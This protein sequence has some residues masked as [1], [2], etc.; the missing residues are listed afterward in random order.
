MK[1]TRTMSE[2]TV[3]VKKG[4]LI[5][6]VKANKL[7]HVKDYIQALDDY[8][9][10]ALIQLKEL[11]N[12]AKDGDVRINLTLVT[13]INNEKEYDKLLLMLEMEIDEEIELSMT[14]FNEYVHDETHFALQATTSNMMYSKF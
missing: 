3:K 4:E 1:R 2:R 10:E 8:K 11:T 6:K 5:E 7:K 14:E 12:R 13:P 9:D